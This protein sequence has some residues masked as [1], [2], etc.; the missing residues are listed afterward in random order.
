MAEK[1]LADFDGSIDG[2]EFIPSSGGRYEVIA[3]GE[4]IYSKEGTGRH[5]E[6][7]E[8]ADAVRALLA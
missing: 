5:A 3:A 7:E 6:Y 4:L 8:V 1:L 2:L